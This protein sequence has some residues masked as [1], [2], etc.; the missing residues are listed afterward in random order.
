[1]KVIFGVGNPGAEYASTRHNLGFMV[2][3]ELVRRHGGRW[4]RRGES[5]VAGVEIR[6]VRSLLVK[7]QTYVNSCG[8]AAREVLE[9][10]AA[11]V[12]DLMVVLDDANLGVGKLRV[13]RS[14]S[15]GGHNGLESLVAELGDEGFARLRIGIGMPREGDLIDYVLGKFSEEEWKAVRGA[16]LAASDAAE[17]WTELGVDECMNRHN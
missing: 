3:D 7:P 17:L 5:F 15:S 1:M 2:A 11:G 16:I 14:G 8:V 6:G 9:R 10:G 12:G 4:K 13:R